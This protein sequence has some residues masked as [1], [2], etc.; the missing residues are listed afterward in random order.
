M[1]TLFIG[2]TQRQIEIPI[3]PIDETHSYPEPLCDWIEPAEYLAKT[4]YGE[5]NTLDKRQQAAVVWCVLNRVDAGWGT[6]IECVTSPKQFLGYADSNP[7]ITEQFE[8]ALDILSRWLAEKN[9]SFMVGRVLPKDYLYFTGDLKTENI[10]R[11]AYIG[12]QI[13]DWSYPNPYEVNEVL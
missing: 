6:V 2:A 5:A 3:Q 11:N 8:L 1:T 7:I 4:I 12:G 9:N 13:W 10:F